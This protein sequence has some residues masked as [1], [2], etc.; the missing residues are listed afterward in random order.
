MKKKLILIFI[1]AILTALAFP[2]YKLG[3]VAYFSPV[4][5]LYLL[6]NVRAKEAFAIGYVWGS[7]FN[8]ALLYGVLWATV[9][10]TFGAIIILALVPAFQCWLYRIVANRSSVLGLILWPLIWTAFDYLRTF[11]EFNFPWSDFAYTQSY[12]LPLIQISE[13]TGLYGV[14]L[15]VYIV[16]VLL[17][18]AFVINVQH[19]KKKIIL[20][21]AL[22][23]PLIFYVY[24]LIRIPADSK[25]GN[26]RIAIAQGNIGPDIKWENGGD[27][28]S[29]DT[30]I[31]LTK[32]AAQNNAIMVVWPETAMPF[33]LLHDPA[34]YHALKSLVDSLNI[35]VL[36]GIPEYEQ[37]GK[38]EYIYFNAAALIR[39]GTY[40]IQTYSKIKLLPMSER[41]P[42][43]GR[44]KIL[45]DIHLGQ[46]D[47][48]SGRKPVLFNLDS[49][50]FATLIC[51][52]SAFPGYC[53]DF[54]RNGAMFLVVITN[55][56]WFGPSSIPYQHAQMSIFRAIENRVPVV[57]CAN[58][59]VS[60]FIDSWGR[61]SNQTKTFVPALEINDVQPAQSSSM[62]NR[63]GNWLP[64]ICVV[65]TAFIIAFAFLGRKGYI[66]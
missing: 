14:S 44:F 17:F 5:L 62:Y 51:F 15:M 56:M 2:P 43:S 48:S 32:Q 46:A 30:Y 21:T 42:F 34:K 13:I 45:K 50:K 33:Y 26:T 10:G 35:S 3:F 47:F 12:Y 53:A 19:I 59:G 16:N 39:P 7:V 29:Y 8:M 65:I 66:G 27:R 24:G 61:V 9:P 6:D 58:T 40:P 18:S 23:L 25:P 57:R 1:S 38:N 54:C 55:D 60:M 31:N 28:L 63:Y 36:T 22:C 41:I 64:M 11:S 20:V 37:V 4:L 52:E 49:V